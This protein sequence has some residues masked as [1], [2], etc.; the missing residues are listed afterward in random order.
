MSKV[1]AILEDNAARRT[2]MQQLAADKFFMYPCRFF[3]ASAPM[4]EWL[5]K[6]PL[7]LASTTTWSRKR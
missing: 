1:I 2:A 3:V 4:I 6:T 7:P 5:R